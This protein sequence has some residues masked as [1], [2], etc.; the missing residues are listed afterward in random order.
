MNRYW[1]GLVRLAEKN[2]RRFKPRQGRVAE[3]PLQSF[4]A[5]VGLRGNCH[6][7]R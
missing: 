3:G 2:L 1:K 7:C 6:W 4:L 5:A